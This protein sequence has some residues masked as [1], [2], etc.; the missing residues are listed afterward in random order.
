[1]V[2][3][4]FINSE[5]FTLVIIPILI[6]LSRVA[7][8]SIGTLRIILLSKGYVFLAPLLGFFEV[9]IWLLA[10][11][12]VLVNLNTIIPLL[13]YALGFAA[14]TYVGII[15]EQKMAVGK[16]LIR[17]IT[18]RDAKKI[19]KAFKDE[20][21]PLINIHGVSSWGKTQ[22]IFLVIRRKR[23]SAA[24]NFIQEIDPKASYS[25]EDIRWAT[26]YHP[27]SRKRWS[28]LGFGKFRKSK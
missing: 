26:E 24:L 25:L 13:A 21:F 15:I 9:M 23:V 1:M 2:L 27:Y 14:G 19:L 22:M 8:V 7:D 3:E 20:D 16:V 6:F 12:Q 28:W 17:I 5:T 18:N 11:R 4:N 10:A